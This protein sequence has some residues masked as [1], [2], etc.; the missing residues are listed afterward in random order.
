MKAGGYILIDGK[1]P[2]RIGAVRSRAELREV[3]PL[4]D[5]KLDRRL[6]DPSTIRAMLLTIDGYEDFALLI[7]TVTGWTAA[8]GTPI[9]VTSA[10]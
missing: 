4:L 6:S 10:G 5:R 1:L 3:T 9:S 7:E 2:A 8:D